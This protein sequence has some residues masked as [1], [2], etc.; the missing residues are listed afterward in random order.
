MQWLA[1][2]LSMRGA[3]NA[4]LQIRRGEAG[5]AASSPKTAEYLGKPVKKVPFS[6]ENP[7]FCSITL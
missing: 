3:A 5:S 7:N 2:R 1:D 6:L 4:S